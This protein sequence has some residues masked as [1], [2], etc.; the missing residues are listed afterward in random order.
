MITNYILILKS[1]N[2]I[3]I[4]IWKCASC[5]KAIKLVFSLTKNDTYA[6]VQKPNWRPTTPNWRPTDAQLTPNYA[7]LTPN[8]IQ[9]HPTAYSWAH[10]WPRVMMP[11]IKINRA[12]I[13]SGWPLAFTSL[14]WPMRQRQMIGML[15]PALK[16]LSWFFRWP[17]QNILYDKEQCSAFTLG[18]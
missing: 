8:Y 9:L 5:I 18:K 6:P 10:K 12:A 17:L 13:I 2:K 15:H 11:F 1:H 16:L 4:Y 14:R 7:Q 3:H